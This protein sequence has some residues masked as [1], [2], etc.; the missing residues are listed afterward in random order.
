[1]KIRAFGV[2]SIVFLLSACGSVGTYNVDGKIVQGG[3]NLRVAMDEA[4]AATQRQLVSTMRVAAPI[5]Q[6]NLIIG[7]P[8]EQCLRDNVIMPS[9]LQT[10]AIHVI[11]RNN[12][13]ATALREAQMVSEIVQGVGIYKTVRVVESGCIHMTPSATDSVLYFYAPPASNTVQWYMNGTTAGQKP[14]NADRSEARYVGK[15][16]AMINAVK[17]YA[18]QD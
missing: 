16:A 10:A 17:G 9:F 1:M 14:I 5:S 18:L 8:T 6:K 2:I 11:N 12:S 13:A 4:A 7:M 3:E 15:V